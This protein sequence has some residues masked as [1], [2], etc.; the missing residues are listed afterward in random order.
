[1]IGLK[2]LFFVLV[3]LIHRAS[4]IR[5]VLVFRSLRFIHLLTHPHLFIHVHL[6]KAMACICTF[7]RE[8]PGMDGLAACLR[9]AGFMSVS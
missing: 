1:M 8:G 4:F 2:G 9:Q 6:L 3:R 5:L 7:F